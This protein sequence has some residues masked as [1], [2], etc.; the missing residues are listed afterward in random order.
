ALRREG[1]LAST[2]KQ[3]ARRS[4]GATR[5]EAKYGLGVIIRP[6]PLGISYG[7]S[8][9]F[10]DYITEVMYFPEA[11][12]AIAMQVNTS[13]PRST[14]KP[15]S[16]FITEMAEIVIK[17]QRSTDESN[18]MSVFNQLFATMEAKRLDALR[19]L[20]IPEG[21]LVSAIQR[22]GQ[23]SVRLLSLE[24]FVKLVA[25]AKEPFR[26]RMFDTEV[27]VRGDMAELWGRYDFHVGTR[28]TNCGYNS[29]E[30][31]RIK[32]EWKIINIASTII[33]EGCRESK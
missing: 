1:V 32:G 10:P 25:D 26:E 19:G 6:T 29:I 28:L 14:P 18:V 31:M 22:Q 4:S 21:R 24:D 9:F 2:I 5:P 11:R 20:F 27:R 16:R 12:L 17:E 8:G 7:H 15:L 33:T 13:V 23:S 3:Y 30:F